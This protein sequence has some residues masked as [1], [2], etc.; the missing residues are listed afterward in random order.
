MYQPAAD[1]A[2]GN[3]GCVML[4]YLDPLGGRGDGERE[5]GHVVG[6]VGE[7]SVVP[8]R[9]EDLEAGDVGGSAA[10]LAPDRV[11]E[12]HGE[13]ERGLCGRDARAVSLNTEQLGAVVDLAAGGSGVADEDG[14][15]GGEP[16]GAQV[17]PVDELFGKVELVVGDGRVGERENE[18]ALGLAGGA[19]TGGAAGQD[20]G[21]GGLVEEVERCLVAEGQGQA[22]GEEVPDDHNGVGERLLDT[23]LG[24]RRPAGLQD[25]R[26]PVG[27]LQLGDESFLAPLLVRGRSCSIPARPVVIGGMPGGC[28]AGT[29][30]SRVAG[31]ALHPPVPGPGQAH[32]LP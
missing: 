15:Q 11:V 7:V 25:C 3:Y 17:E 1:G 8:G 4:T 30:D 19:F 27:Q 23:E 14:D 12:G 20:Q 28:P 29:A 6:D 5:A 18:G 13:L 22:V 2:S 31:R 16:G 9:G 26:V 32:Q 24:G 10:G 21:A